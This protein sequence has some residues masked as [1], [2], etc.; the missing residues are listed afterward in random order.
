MVV[1]GWTVRVRDREDSGG[2]QWEAKR[3]VKS[4]YP[5]ARRKPENLVKFTSYA[6]IKRKHWISGDADTLLTIQ[7][8][9]AIYCLPLHSIMQERY[10]SNLLYCALRIIHISAIHVVS[11]LWDIYCN[12]SIIGRR[13][14]IFLQ[15]IAD[16]SLE[17]IIFKNSERQKWENRIAIKQVN[18]LEA[19]IKVRFPTKIS[20]ERNQ[21]LETFSQ[22]YRIFF[23]RLMVNFRGFSRNTGEARLKIKHV[24]SRIVIELTLLR[25]PFI[26]WPPAF[27]EI[28]SSRHA[29]LETLAAHFHMRR[30][31]CKWL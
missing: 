11:E 12:R 6:R 26:K 30:V 25:R 29:F 16:I 24:R 17:I 23:H 7:Q 14:D 19:N 27:N 3:A 22:V 20:P 5:S 10:A 15:L 13:F 28:K 21:I 8:K 1:W 2:K 18:K 4:L 31:A 9:I